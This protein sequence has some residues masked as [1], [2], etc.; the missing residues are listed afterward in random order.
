MITRAKSGHLK[1]RQ[2]LDLNH[3]LVPA[4]PTS[5]TQD[6]Q[7]PAWRDAMSKEFQALQTQGTWILVPSTSATN[8]LGCKWLFKTKYH[9]NGTIARYKARLV[10]QGF[11]Q[12]Y[13]LDYIE[14]FSPVAKF[15]TIR[16][17]LT[18]AVTNHWPLYQLDVSNAFLHGPLLETVYMKQPPGFVDKQFPTHHST[19]RLYIIVYVDDILVTG[20]SVAALDK[21]LLALHSQFSMRNLGKP[22]QFLGLQVSEIPNGIH[23]TQS[24]Y[25]ASILHKAAMDDCKPVLTSLPT[26]FTKVSSPDPPYDRPEHYRQLTGALQYLTLTRPDLSFAVNF[27]CQHM[28]CPLQS[29]YLLLK[30]VLRYIQGTLSLGLPI[31]AS[32]LIL[33]GFADSD[34]AT[35]PINRRSISGY[36]AFLGSNLISWQVKKQT[37]VARSSTEAEYRALSTAACD[38]IW[39]RR[40]LSEFQ[41]SQTQPTPLYCDN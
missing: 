32:T 7:Y 40:L 18:V 24:H 27:L 30:C 4:A 17:F 19:V 10:A 11:K 23:L 39:I 5:F 41:L 14:T 3:E 29:H 9:S 16:I 20:N 26:T 15:P 8:V 38:I 33:Q 13:G 37:S 31:T 6:I 12:E 25:A 35:D 34:W 2:I 36:C 22:H 28:H 1:P 21:L